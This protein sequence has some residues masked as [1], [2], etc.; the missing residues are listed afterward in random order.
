MADHTTSDDAARYRPPEEVEAWRLRDPLL[1]LERFLA[2]RGLWSTDYGAEM[3][4][5]SLA[6]VD[7]AVQAMEALPPPEP[8]DL[9]NHTLA[10]LTPRQAGQIR[11]V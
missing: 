2:G 7:A 5:R 9:F 10:R 1:R 8:A 3:K 6:T 11:A 4:A